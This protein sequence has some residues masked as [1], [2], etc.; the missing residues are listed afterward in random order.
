VQPGGTLSL[1]IGVVTPPPG[2]ATLHLAMHRNGSQFGTTLDLP[3][4]IR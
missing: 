1:D 2:T 4:V 3:E